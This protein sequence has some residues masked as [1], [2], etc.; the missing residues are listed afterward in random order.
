MELDVAALRQTC[1]GLRWVPSEQQRADA[2]TKRSRALRDSFREWMGR[3]VVRL[4]DSKSPAD[5]GS[6]QEANQAWRP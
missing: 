5:V 2:M 4:T 3:P 6:G 1:R